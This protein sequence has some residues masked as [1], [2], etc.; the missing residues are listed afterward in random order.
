MTKI[1]PIKFNIPFTKGEESETFTFSKKWTVPRA[2][3][4]LASGRLAL[5][6]ISF[7]RADDDLVSDDVIIGHSVLTHVGI[8]TKSL[9]EKNRQK[10]DGT[11]S[12]D[13]GNPSRSNGS[14]RVSTL[15]IARANNLVTNNNPDQLNYFSSREDQDPF[16]NPTLLDK[17]G[18]DH[19]QEVR[20]AIHD[21]IGKTERNGLGKDEVDRISELVNANSNVFRTQLSN[22]EPARIKP[23]SIE[24]SANASPIRVKLRK[25]SQEQQ[26]FM[27]DIVKSLERKGMVYLNTS[28][29]WASAP[30]L[31][32]KPGLAK[33]RFTVDLRPVNQFTKKYQYPMPNMEVELTKLAGERHFASFDFAYGYWQLPVAKSSQ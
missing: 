18:E 26:K 23:L 17:V 30:L 9:S 25:Y 32:P 2:T 20:R 7:L 31:V 11:D 1:N 4:Y 27:A 5:T 6:H 28:T 29:K 15:M 33:F 10:L 16:K 12:R 22:G 24:L 19:E 8:D 13:V 3:L 14:G 21:L